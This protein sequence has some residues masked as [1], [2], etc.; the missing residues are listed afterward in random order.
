MNCSCGSGTS[1]QEPWSWPEGHSCC[2]LQ[3]PR[4]GAWL[5]VTCPLSSHPLSSPS[6]SPCWAK[7]KQGVQEP[8]CY[9]PQGRTQGHSLEEL[10]SGAVGLVETAQHT[11]AGQTRREV[12]RV[13]S[14]G[15]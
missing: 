11:C 12:G 6:A 1:Q 2:Q 4:E 10:E 13:E 5:E 7:Q 8:G 9:G 15:N 3:L 14:L